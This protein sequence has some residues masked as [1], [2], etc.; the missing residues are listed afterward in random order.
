MTTFHPGS[1]S[2]EA[3]VDA[4]ALKVTLRE[5]GWRT[6]HDADVVLRSMTLPFYPGR[7]LIMATC[8][9]WQPDTVALY[10]LEGPDG[11]YRLNGVAPP[12]H[13]VNA[14][15]DQHI[16]EHMAIG[17]MI[18]FCF[19]VRG[20]D[21]PFLILASLE[22]P[23]LPPALRQAGGSEA[24][25]EA[26]R[27]LAARYQSP[28]Y[29]GVDAEGRLR[30]SATLMYSDAIFV[31]DFLVHPGGMVEMIDDSTVLAGLPCR[32]DAPITLSREFQP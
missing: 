5:S 4:E 2:W 10:W 20:D 24:E 16:T 8:S 14:K 26:G 18:F 19:F 31:A 25:S 15:S 23:Y 28:R 32:I 6:E 1:R 30:Y 29:H 3:A 21:G 7:R 22:D 17:Y 9:R 12:V 13:E 11:V 27:L